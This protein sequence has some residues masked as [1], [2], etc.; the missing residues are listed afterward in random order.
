MALCSFPEDPWEP[1]YLDELRATAAAMGQSLIVTRQVAAAD[2]FGGAAFELLFAVSWRYL[3]RPEVYH[4]AQRGA[5]VFHD[6]LLPRRRGFAPTPWAIIEGD[7]TT[8]VTLLEMA[9]AADRGRI[10]DQVAVPVGPDEYIDRVMARVTEAYL[11]VLERNLPALLAGTAALREQNEAQA[12]YGAKRRPEDNRITWQA[13]AATIFNLIRACSRP[14]PGAF[15]FR[16]GQ[17]LTVWRADAPQ[18]AAPVAAAVGTILERV[19]GAGARVAT[20]DGTLLLRELQLEGQ[21]TVRADELLQTAE[22]LT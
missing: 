10:V 19:P 3:V 15:C 14:Y 21:P 20:R 16:N 17:R 18:S 9:E 7:N 13:P 11:Q 22:V 6:S 4:R 2:L 1:R 5:F 12:T 8:G